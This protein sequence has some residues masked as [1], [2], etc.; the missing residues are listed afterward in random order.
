MRRIQRR[1]F[2]I[3]T[4]ALLAA[5][6]AKAQTGSRPRRIAFVNTTSPLSELV[7][8]EP[9]HP[10]FR[11]LLHAL[12]ALGW[13]EGHNLLIDRRSAEGHFERAP[14]IFSEVV[15]RGAEMIITV[16]GGFV[17]AALK[18]APGVPIVMMAIGPDVKDI[19]PNYSHP[20]GQITGVTV[21]VGSEFEAKRLQLLK[22]M[23]PGAR[24]VAFLAVQ[25]A[26]SGTL[27][28]ESLLK[29][30]QA[31]GLVL[32]PAE[33]SGNT[34]D[35]A[36][37][38]IKLRRPDALLVGPQAPHYAHRAQIV[39]FARKMRLPDFHAYQEAVDSGGLASYGVDIGDMWYKAA[40]QVDRILKGAK[41]GDL[42]IQQPTKFLFTINLRTA[43]ALGIKVP[44]SIL[45]RADTVRE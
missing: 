37:S 42:S 29:A 32:V 9:A 17:R 14:A 11:A 15:Q 4:G 31:L 23:L 2:V 28:D 40:G 22:E 7:G 6:L 45:L 16:G 24:S 5:A 36:L 12:R 34:F 30:A 20:G 43:K 26:T 33:W 39:E 19:V 27:V 3:A 10:G 44:Q 18:A 35:A 8:P 38:L 25:V 41:P 1:R 21:E 13:I